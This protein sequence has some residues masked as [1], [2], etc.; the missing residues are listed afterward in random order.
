MPLPAMS[1]AEPCTASKMAASTPMFAPGAIPSPPTSPAISSER[2]SPKRFVVTIVSN[3]H[4]FSTSCIA[5][6]ST[7]R[8]S[9]CTL[10]SY[11]FATSRAVSRKTPVSALSTFALWTM[12]TFLRPCFTA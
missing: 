8:S 3:C 4:G 11:F 5:Q 2:M 9:T 10:P 7:M 12:V 1:G 6:A